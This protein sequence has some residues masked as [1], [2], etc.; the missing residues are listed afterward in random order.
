[1]KFK[2]SKHLNNWYGITAQADTEI[3]VPENLVEKA[4]SMPFLS[5]V[6]AKKRVEN[7]N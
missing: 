3:D 4:K 2:T 5:P 6:K 7:V 1:M